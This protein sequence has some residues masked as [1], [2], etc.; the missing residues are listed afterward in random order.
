[1]DLLGVVDMSVQRTWK[2]SSKEVKLKAVACRGGGA[3]GATAL[4]IQGRG[5]SKE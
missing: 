1:M 5:A 2:V 4:G 3:K